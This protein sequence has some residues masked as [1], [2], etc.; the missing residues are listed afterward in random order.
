MKYV[1]IFKAHINI[2]DDEYFQTAKILREKALNHF[3]C[4]KFEA[5]SEQAFEIALSY[6]NSLDDIQ[7]WK[8]DAEHIVAQQQGNTRWYEGYSVEICEIHHQYSKNLL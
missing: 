3:N 2:L 1:V 4:Q 6:W 5:I 7:A 8:K